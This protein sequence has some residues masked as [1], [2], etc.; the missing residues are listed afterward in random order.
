MTVPPVRAS[1]RR[2]LVGDRP[3]VPTVLGAG[4]RLFPDGG[5]H[6]ELRCCERP[7]L[8]VTTQ[9]VRLLKGSTGRSSPDPGV[10]YSRIVIN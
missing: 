9:D 6:L 5:W 1:P 10:A 2:Q 7:P 8:A 3:R 4:D